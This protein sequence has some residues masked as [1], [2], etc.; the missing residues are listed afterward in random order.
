MN[1]YWCLLVAV[2]VSPP[3]R[4][5]RSLDGVAAVV[6]HEI[7][8]LSEVDSRANMALAAISSDLSAEQKSARERE[9]RLQALDQLIE[10]KLLQQK[11]Q[12]HHIAVTDEEVD[13]QI[14]WLRQRNRMSEE[15]FREALKV[16][17]QTMDGL[18]A[19]LRGQLEQ[20]K[21]LDTQLRDNPELRAR[22]LVTEHDIDSAYQARYASEKAKEQIKARHILIRLA[23]DATAEQQQAALAKAREVLALLGKGEPF[24]KLAADYSDDTSSTVGGELGWFRRGDMMPDFEDPAFAL[25]K[26]ATSQPVR[27]S[28]GYHIIQVTDRKQEGPPDLDKVR[29][30]IRNQ[31]AREKFQEALDTW[32]K[33]LREQSYLDIKL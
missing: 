33:M 21:L 17:G 11:V 32:I 18:R 24:E 5:G 20:Q 12:E 30:Q 4:A 9:I 2:L 28:L 27:T 15:Q 19:Q 8:L 6:N 25:T 14:E 13:G 26:G 31:L 3:A 29:D 10:E 23:A 16:E 7:I 1:R 22:L